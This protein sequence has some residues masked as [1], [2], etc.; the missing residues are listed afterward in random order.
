[1]MFMVIYIKAHKSNTH[2]D[3]EVHIFVELR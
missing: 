3:A 2:T 1:M